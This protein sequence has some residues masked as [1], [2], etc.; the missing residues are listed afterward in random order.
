MK[1]KQI[2]VYSAIFLAFV[3]CFVSCDPSED[4]VDLTKI[5]VW[6]E[7]AKDLDIYSQ[8]LAMPGGKTIH[9]IYV[10]ST[11]TL[12]DRPLIL[13][14]N[15]GPGMSSMLG[16]A[17]EIGPVVV[18]D[19]EDEWS[20]NPKHW[21][22]F[23]HLLFFDAPAGVGF[24]SPDPNEKAIFSDNH[25]AT[26]NYEAL[27]G[28]FSKYP[29]F[30]RLPFYIAGEQYGGV[31]A[32][33]LAKTILDRN[34]TD[35]TKINFKG[36]IL[37]NAIINPDIIEDKYWEFLYGHQILNH[38]TWETFTQACSIDK[39]APR[40]VFAKKK[41]ENSISYLNMQDIYRNCEYV[42]PGPPSS[43]GNK[44]A[45]RRPFHRRAPFLKDGPYAEGNYD[46]ID[47]DRLANVLNKKEFQEAF[48]V[49]T[50]LPLNKWF[51][52]N[53][54]INQKYQMTPTGSY[55]VMQELFNRQPEKAE[56]KFKFLIYH[57][58]TDAEVPLNSAEAW[59]QG[60]GLHP[61]AL[62]EPWGYENQT[63]GFVTKYQQGITF[64]TIRGVGQSAP[65]WKRNEVS[66]LVE[67]WLNDLPI[68]E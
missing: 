44:K 57:G 40:C 3:L 24:S 68:T 13:W 67:N 31:H 7:E 30:T 37:G 21:A 20:F 14:L 26:D 66:F 5:P 41:V 48:H 19:G 4:K 15:G 46:C 34:P 32:P 33:F 9:Y 35:L 1:A 23:A 45:I 36:L 2:L 22:R 12:P 27:L 6:P 18:E 28:F 11:S 56:N 54:T 64:A 29:K 10:E 25:T 62:W 47:S 49:P 61:E 8:G 63:D 59:I 52:Y 51:L 58:D 55:A 38:D 50:N 65:Q 53:S 42:A 43:N 60:L 16:F 17:K 39:N